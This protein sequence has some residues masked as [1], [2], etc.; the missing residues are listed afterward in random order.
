MNTPYDFTESAALLEKLFGLTRDGKIE[1]QRNN[2][3][4]RTSEIMTTCRTT[5]DKDLDALIW[6]NDKAAGFRLSEKPD[7]ALYIPEISAISGRDLLSISI[8]HDHSAEQGAIYVL[9]MG[10]L[11]LARRSVDKIEPKIDRVKQYLDKLAV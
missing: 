10:L 8:N 5:L 9:L 3:V 2:L 4:S 11:E 6:S 7:E 1:W